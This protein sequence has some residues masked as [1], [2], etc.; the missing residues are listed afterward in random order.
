MATPASR[1]D[2]MFASQHGHGVGV[3]VQKIR[4]VGRGRDLSSLMPCSLQ[5][6]TCES[7]INSSPEYCSVA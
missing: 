4:K 3:H 1:E 6:L 2:S 5:K 7:C